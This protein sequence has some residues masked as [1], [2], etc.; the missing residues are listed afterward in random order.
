MYWVSAGLDNKRL[1]YSPITSKNAL[2][3]MPRAEVKLVPVFF[4]ERMASRTACTIAT[5]DTNENTT[6][7]NKKGIQKVLAWTT[8]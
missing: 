5:E 4:K 6:S 1:K 3:S 2:G 8:H 7:S